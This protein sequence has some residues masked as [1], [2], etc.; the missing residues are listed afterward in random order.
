MPVRIDSSWSISA[1]AP[2]EILLIK[3]LR[4]FTS[5]VGSGISAS[6]LIA[7]KIFKERSVIK[8][9]RPL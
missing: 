9:N 7:L 8:H 6:S 4:S 5:G 1:L 2:L 3:L